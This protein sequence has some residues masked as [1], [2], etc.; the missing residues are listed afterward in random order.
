M[1]S[2]IAKSGN[3]AAFPTSKSATRFGRQFKPEEFK[4]LQEFLKSA[5]EGDEKLKSLAEIADQ[6]DP[7]QS[8]IAKESRI[9]VWNFFRHTLPNMIGRTLQRLRLLKKP[10]NDPT[11]FSARLTKF[12]T[13]ARADSYMAAWE[14]GN[15]IWER[16]GHAPSNN[17]MIRL[18][19]K[20]V[21]EILV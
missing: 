16:R 11:P 4:N 18:I 1:P 14:I 2:A 13:E 8:R 17:I 15:K 10:E 7:K 19:E 3:N 20:R 9:P 12:A 5:A 21:L 6:L